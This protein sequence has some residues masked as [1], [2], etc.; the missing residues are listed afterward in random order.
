M[1]KPKEPNPHIV[2]VLTEWMD[3]RSRLERLYQKLLNRADKYVC[4]ARNGVSSQISELNEAIHTVAM[5]VRGIET[6]IR[7]SEAM[8]RSRKGAKS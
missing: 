1:K 5:G 4:S 2:K 7:I 3:K 8:K 6:R